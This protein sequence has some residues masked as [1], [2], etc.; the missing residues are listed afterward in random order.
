MAR[1]P[2]ESTDAAS[3]E[4]PTCFGLS[5]AV[6]G[7][8]T[9]RSVIP[10]VRRVSSGSWEALSIIL[11]GVF[12]IIVIDNLK[13]GVIKPCVYDPELN[14]KL[15]DFASHYNTC[16]MPAK[17]A[18]SRHKGKT[19]NSV[20][21]AQGNALKGLKFSSG[22]DQNDFLLH[23]E[24]TVADMR[25]RD[26]VKHQVFQ[27]FDKE[28]PYLR[29]LPKALSSTFTEVNRKVHQDGYVEEAKAFLSE[30]PDHVRQEVLGRY[31][32]H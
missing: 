12:D 3:D 26:T 1:A 21:Y 2:G 14:P 20:D 32:G 19:D 27:M 15:H 9:A 11:A 25:I 16:V 5:R 31:D 24:K 18:T 13:A 30:P 17:V 23:W 10:R 6:P 28:K 4:K 7:R 22:Q 8:S 29:K